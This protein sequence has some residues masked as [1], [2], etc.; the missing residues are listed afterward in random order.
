M[1][2]YVT[3]YGKIT[4]NDI[5][6]FKKKFPYPTKKNEGHAWNYFFTKTWGENLEKLSN[7]TIINSL[8]T[9]FDREGKYW[10]DDEKAVNYLANYADGV[11]YFKGEDC[12][13][14]KWT[15]K[16]KKAVKKIRPEFK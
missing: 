11:L 12:V 16:E 8:E 3:V 9:D 7:G 15:F 10:Y 2:Y 1:G 5:E 13:E 6:G 4:F 14:W